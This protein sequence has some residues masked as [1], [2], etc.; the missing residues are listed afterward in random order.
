M[1]TVDAYA[2]LSKELA[3]AAALPPEKL[4]QW[5]DG[6]P[7][8]RTVDVSGE[9]VEIEIDVTWHGSDRAAVRISAHARGPSTWHHQRC[10]ESV[11]V[12]IRTAGTNSSDHPSPDVNLYEA[13]E[14]A[15]ELV[16][17]CAAGS[18]SFEDFCILYDNFYWS[19][20]LDG[21]ESDESTLARY[22]ARIA[23]HKLVAENILARVCADADATR[24]AFRSAGRISASEAVAKLKD[25]VGALPPQLRL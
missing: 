14:R 4:V 19:L 12:Q 16:R 18:L 6:K 1:Q 9:P 20:A 23:P 17:R 7:C 3:A 15:D 5:A 13:L 2:I 10:S 11:V 21:H 22:T 24:E 25:V 8:S